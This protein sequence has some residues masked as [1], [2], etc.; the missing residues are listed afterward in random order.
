MPDSASLRPNSEWTPNRQ[1][2]PDMPLP[3]TTQEPTAAS[4][5]PARFLAL[6]PAARTLWLWLWAAAAGAIAAAAT[7]AFRW[8]TQQVEWLA[9]GRVLHAKSRSNSC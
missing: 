2:L 7:M 5:K 1:P 6:A 8:L 3:G 4:G 9:T